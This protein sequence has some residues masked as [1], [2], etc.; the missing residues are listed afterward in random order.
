MSLGA[1]L[2]IIPPDETPTLLG[3]RE[4]SGSELTQYH[5]DAALLRGVAPIT[6]YARAADAVAALAELAEQLANNSD[7]GPLGRRGQKRLRRALELVARLLADLPDQLEQTLRDR[8]GADGD[9]ARRLS[10]EH[11]GLAA[12]SPYRLASGFDSLPVEH[13]RLISDDENV[14]LAVTAE[15]VAEWSVGRTEV[16]PPRPLGLVATAETALVLSQ[17]MLSQWLIEHKEVVREASLR[18]ARLAS[19]IIEGAPVVTRFR[20]RQRGED[21]EPEVLGMKPDPIPLQEL[22]ALQ[23]AILRAERILAAELKQ[24]ALRG[25]PGMYPEQVQAVLE[26]TDPRHRFGDEEHASATDEPPPDGDSDEAEE[27]E[28]GVPAIDLPTVIRHLE[29]GTMSLE[30]AWSRALKE[31]GS[32]RMIAQWTSMVETLRAEMHAADQRLPEDDRYLELPPT[33]EEIARLDLAPDDGRAVQQ[34]RLAQTMV[35]VELIR[36]IPDLARPTVT[37][38]DRERDLYSAWI[39]SGAFAAVRDQLGLIADLLAE[40]PQTR[41]RQVHRSALL[42]E[43]ALA[44]GDPEATLLHAARVFRAEDQPTSDSASGDV[45]KLVKDAAERLAAGEQLDLAAV[46]LLAHEASA[47]IHAMDQPR[48]EATS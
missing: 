1:Q 23:G 45:R 4:L 5:E 8:F 38:L 6:P 39:S 31:P 14:E 46:T 42:A 21:E 19:E 29:F 28:P 41:L 20:I 33:A 26:Q 27:G 35:L 7:E 40:P 22:H 15:G 18:V 48:D 24:P 43:R 32:D 25:Q 9:A 16:A 44:R 11:T 30:Q 36:S 37:L 17:K 12:Q 34:A 47:L 10:E 3:V 13:V 2:P